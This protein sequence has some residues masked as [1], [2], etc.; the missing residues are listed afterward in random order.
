MFLAE[1]RA[2]EPTGVPHQRPAHRRRTLSVVVDMLLRLVR[3]VPA[4]FLFE[5]SRLVVVIDA[6]NIRAN[7]AFQRMEHRASAKT[8][9]RTTPIRTC[10][11]ID[12]VVI[13]I[14]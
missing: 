9:D 4:H 11:Q 8:V 7:D 1:T 12:G 10:P 6:S 14:R 5:A 13:S 3:V 2:D